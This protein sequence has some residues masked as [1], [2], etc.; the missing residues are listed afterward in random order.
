M[1]TNS[2]ICTVVATVGAPLAGNRAR[3]FAITNGQIWSA[4]P[5]DD[6]FPDENVKFLRHDPANGAI[7]ENVTFILDGFGPFN[8][9]VN[10]AG[11][12]ALAADPTT[13]NVYTLFQNVYV[14]DDYRESGYVSPS[15]YDRTTRLLGKVDLTTGI[16]TP[17]CNT[18]DLPSEMSSITFDG[19]GNLWG[20]SQLR[21]LKAH[22][23]LWMLPADELNNCF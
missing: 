2:D 6:V 13:G 8:G 20:V 7:L 5:R 23:Y 12:Y 22:K 1:D 3:G 16:V 14:D 11:A 19:A 21:D 4:T 17:T 18:L 15:E 10:R 9:T